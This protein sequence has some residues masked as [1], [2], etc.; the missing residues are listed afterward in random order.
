LA[1]EVRGERRISIRVLHP[2]VRFVVV[3]AMVRVLV[4]G[5]SENG[6]GDESKSES[7][8][9]RRYQYMTVVVSSAVNL[10]DSEQTNSSHLIY[11]FCAGSAHREW[12]AINFWVELL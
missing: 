12:E 7:Q 4:L 9:H 11:L 8:L 10:V 3:V 2:A 1:I 5:S 6:E